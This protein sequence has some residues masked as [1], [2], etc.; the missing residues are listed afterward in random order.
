MATPEPAHE[1]MRA[2]AVEARMIAIELRRE[3]RELLARCVEQR[4]IR[5]HGRSAGA[6]GANR[7]S[8]A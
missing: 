8:P 7:G 6:A 2:Q 5:S 1:Q 4:L 3:S